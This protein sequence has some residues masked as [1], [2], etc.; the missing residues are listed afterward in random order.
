[1][2]LREYLD[3]YNVSIAAFA[4]QI[5][6]DP[7][8]IGDYLLGKTRVSERIAMAIERQTGRKVKKETVLILNPSKAQIKKNETYVDVDLPF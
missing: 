1:M 8:T 6:Y 7:K 3:E 5:G 2:N 4:R